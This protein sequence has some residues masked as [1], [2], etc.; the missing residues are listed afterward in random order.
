MSKRRAAT[1]AAADAARSIAEKVGDGGAATG[2]APCA[3]ASGCLSGCSRPDSLLLPGGTPAGRFCTGNWFG[4]VRTFRH[5]RLACSKWLAGFGSRP[6]GPCSA[7]ETRVSVCAGCD[8]TEACRAPPCSSGGD[9]RLALHFCLVC[10]DTRVLA[11]CCCAAAAS[12]VSV[13]AAL[14]AAD[15]STCCDAASDGAMAALSG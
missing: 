8:G 1:V 5:A 14:P 15:T 4:V 12:R 10:R 13:A 6:C 7:V 11:E 2:T 9:E 3:A